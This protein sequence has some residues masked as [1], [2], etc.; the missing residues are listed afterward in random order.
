MTR[1]RLSSDQGQTAVEFA[2]VAPF[3]VVLLLAVI[4]FGV[5]FHNYVTITDAAR[6]GARKA[7][8]ARFASGNFDDA[9]QAVRDSASNLDQSVL[10]QPGAID[11][12]DPSGMTSGTLVTVT[13]KYPYTISIPLLGMTVSSGTLTAVAKER[14]E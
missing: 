4:Q 13:V 12:S 6:A 8:V 5:A 9:K 11:V 3:I 10:N 7:I 14:L 2:L 1:R